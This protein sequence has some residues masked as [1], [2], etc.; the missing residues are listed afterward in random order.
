[1]KDG[2]RRIVLWWEDW[3]ERST[4]MSSLKDAAGVCCVEVGGGGSAMGK[5]DGDREILGDSDLVSLG[6]LDNARSSHDGRLRRL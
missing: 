2:G 5:G 1:M 6:F 3:R 4:I